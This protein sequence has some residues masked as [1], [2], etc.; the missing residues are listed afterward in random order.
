MKT[1]TVTAYNGTGENK[2]LAGSRDINEPE[3]L[4]E[5]EKEFGEE[6]ALEY[7]M[8]ARVIEVQRQIRA[9][10]TDSD[11][12]KMKKLKAA[13][14]ANPEFAAILKEQGIEFNS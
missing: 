14:A 13:A 9:G 4:D 11:R 1:R 5:A 7:L 3:T 8:S 6:D 10:T 12:A 2:V